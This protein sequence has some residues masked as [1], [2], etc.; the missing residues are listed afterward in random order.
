MYLWKYM[1]FSDWTGDAF[2]DTTL[3]FNNKLYQYMLRI[4]F[5]E[6]MT[7][8][9][10]WLAIVGIVMILTTKENKFKKLTI[11]FLFGSVIYWIIA[12]KI[13]FFHNYYT[14]IIM[15]LFCI[16]GSFAIYYLLVNIQGKIGKAFI[17]ILFFLLIFPKAYADIDNRLKMNQDISEMNEFIF[18][19]TSK[20]DIIINETP[21]STVTIYTGRSLIYMERLVNNTIRNEIKQIGFS[22]TMQK[23][24]VKYLMTDADNPSYIDFA[25]LFAETKIREPRWDRRLL[26]LSTIGNKKSSQN[27]DVRELEK[28]VQDYKIYEKFHLEAKI[29][30]FKFFTFT[31]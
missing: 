6:Y 15:I 24:H 17:I 29:G 5:K 3:L 4:Q 11:S 12:S 13:M 30:K 7:P 14:I 2:T 22:K 10:F 31:D 26:I 9:M 18:R 25:P 1:N 19:N 27:E 23:Y 21:L 20:E 28:I 8:N 16:S